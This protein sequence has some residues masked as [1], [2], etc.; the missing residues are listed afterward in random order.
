MS[1]HNWKKERLT[2]IIHSCGEKRKTSH[3]THLQM[4][5]DTMV[6]AII[7]PERTHIMNIVELLDQLQTATW[8]LSKE[9][10]EEL[11]EAL[12]V[13]ELVFSASGY[14]VFHL[15]DLFGSGYFA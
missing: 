3:L 7:K 12:Y 11:L 4:D 13:L 8:P 6:T 15:K 2:P 5:T 1:R 9:I 10:S 14:N